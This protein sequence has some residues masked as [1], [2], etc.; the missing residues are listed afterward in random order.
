MKTTLLAQTELKQSYYDLDSFWYKQYAV[1][2][3]ETDKEREEF[4]I[5]YRDAMNYEHPYVSLRRR[6]DVSNGVN[7]YQ[8]WDI[9]TVEKN[10]YDAALNIG[11]SDYYDAISLNNIHKQVELYSR[12][13]NEL[14]KELAELQDKIAPCK[15]NRYS[16]LALEYQEKYDAELKAKKLYSRS[17]KGTAPVK[18]INEIR[19]PFITEYNLELERINKRITVIQKELS[20]IKVEDF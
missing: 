19:I 16:L 11:D 3:F 10:I 9:L 6:V 2:Q 12:T 13:R 14:E 1:G 17:Q 5:K 15:H 20:E 18:I 8:E 7:S 4:A